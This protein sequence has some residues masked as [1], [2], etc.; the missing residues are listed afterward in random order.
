MEG[1]T[2]MLNLKFLGNMLQA[3]SPRALAILRIVMGFLFLQH[4]SMKLLGFPYSA[5]E[6]GTPIAS[7]LGVAGLLELLGGCLIM[8]GLLTRP[9]AFLLS[10]EMAVAYF[11]AHAPLGQVLS[12]ALNGGEPAV[13]YCFIFLYLV[14]AGPGTWRVDARAG[15]TVR[16]PAASWTT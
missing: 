8:L 4:G 13:L 14:F 2:H 3:W 15:S 6:A 11:I 10:G 1:E 5:N 7:L 9:V 16:Q 12:P